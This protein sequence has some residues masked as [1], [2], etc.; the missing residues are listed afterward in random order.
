VWNKTTIVTVHDCRDIPYGR[1]PE[2]E[3]ADVKNKT[4]YKQFF[5]F[6]FSQAANQRALVLITTPEVKI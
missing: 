5:Y 3:L 4:N 2:L 1:V 6:L